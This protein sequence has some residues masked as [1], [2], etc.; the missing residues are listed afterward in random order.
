M[1]NSP[2]GERPATREGATEKAS[3]DV[4][5]VALFQSA[6]NPRRE[7]AM[8]PPEAFKGACIGPPEMPDKEPDFAPPLNVPGVHKSFRSFDWLKS[9]RPFDPNRPTVAVF[10][11]FKKSV[12]TPNG[13]NQPGLS[14]GEVSARAA[15]EA[16]FNVLRLHAKGE[17]PQAQEAIKEIRRAMKNGTIPL[18]AGDAINLSL[19]QELKFSE[20]SC[21]LKMNITPENYGE[22]RDEITKRMRQIAGRPQGH[23]MDW[24]RISGAVD[25]QKSIDAIQRQGIDIIHSAGNSGP[26]AFDWEFISARKQL[27]AGDP[28]GRAFPYSSKHG[29]TTTYPSSFEVHYRPAD[30]TSST[31]IAKQVGY[32]QL[33]NYPIRFAAERFGGPP[34]HLTYMRRKDDGDLERGKIE[35][36]PPIATGATLLSPDGKP[37]PFSTA[38]RPPYEGGFTGTAAPITAVAHVTPRTDI[39]SALRTNSARPSVEVIAGTSF[40]NATYWFDRMREWRDKKGLRP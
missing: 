25:M 22:Q 10:D 12:F 2:E 8:P 16:G 18:R 11:D 5:V 17:F 14:H 38:Y 33:D 20:A 29:L 30:L 23:P 39:E 21:A 6:R 27:A 19:G 34:N 36:F 15:Q 4:D 1:S 40:S 32:Y 3:S 24:S 28:Q 37:Q 7:P 26:Q 31:P 35:R 9:E 13:P